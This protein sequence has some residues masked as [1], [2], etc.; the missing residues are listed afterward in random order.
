MAHNF[1]GAPFYPQVIENIIQTYGEELTAVKRNEVS[2][3]YGGTTPSPSQIIF[4]T[5]RGVFYS[6]SHAQIAITELGQFAN[7][8]A[9]KNVGLLLL[10]TDADK[11]DEGYEIEREGKVYRVRS[12]RFYFEICAQAELEVIDRDG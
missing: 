2:D 6:K 12:I 4:V 9:T 8:T 11:I 7:Q 5:M 1:T 3:G 10:K